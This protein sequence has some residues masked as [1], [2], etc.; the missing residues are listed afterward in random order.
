MRAIHMRKLILIPT[1]VITGFLALA[2]VQP[3]GAAGLVRAVAPGLH[4]ALPAAV[5][6]AGGSVLRVVAR[7]SGSG[8]SSQS[9]AGSAQGADQVTNSAAANPH[10]VST[11]SRQNCGRFGNGFHGGK[12]LFVCP[13][14]PFPFPPNR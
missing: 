2:F 3:A 5:S 7:A 9:L 6:A 13:N 1:I 12:H 10:S 11:T 8:A 4:V 14:R